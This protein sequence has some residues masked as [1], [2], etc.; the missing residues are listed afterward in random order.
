MTAGHPLPVI[1]PP[2]TADFVER[3][4]AAMVHDI[5][6]R[7]DH[8]DDLDVPPRCDVTEV[9]DGD[10]LDLD[11]VGVTVRLV[12]HGV[13][14]PA[15]GYR[16]D[17]DGASVAWSGDTLPCAGLDALCAGADVYVQTV[18][19]RSMVEAVPVQRFLDILD[20]HSDVED[21]GRTAAR[22]GV[23]TLVLNHMVPAPLPGTEGD[24]IAE[25]AAHFDGEIVMATDLLRIAV[26]GAR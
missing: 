3:T 21:A 18:I 1:G 8:H 5:G 19:R 17:H 20:Y 2:G 25:A 11:G 26:P 7:I 9:D 15:V 14:R 23:G 24:W 22:A 16:F 4:I 12:D 13:V 10:V 6:Y